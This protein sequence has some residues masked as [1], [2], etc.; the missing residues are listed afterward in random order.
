MISR[1]ASDAVVV[2]DDTQRDV[3]YRR[4][5]ADAIAVTDTSFGDIV[6]LHI[7][8]LA[9]AIA[10]TD[11]VIELELPGQPGWVWDGD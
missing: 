9:D 3:D 6:E 1:E 2:A 5:L 10:V 8:D 7:R 11:Q 4:D